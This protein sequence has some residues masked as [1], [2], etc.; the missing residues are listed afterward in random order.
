MQRLFLFQRNKLLFI[1]HD[2]VFSN[3]FEGVKKH[4]INGL[5]RHFGCIFSLNLNLFLFNKLCNVTQKLRH[6][7]LRKADVYF[8]RKMILN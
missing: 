6:K 3:E 1:H 4:L 7:F 8:G 2:G 5:A